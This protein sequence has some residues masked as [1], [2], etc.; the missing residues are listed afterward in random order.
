MLLGC[1]EISRV[2]GAARALE[3]Y[4]SAARR[5]ASEDG[6]AARR[7]S[8]TIETHSLGWDR[9]TEDECQEPQRK[10]RLTEPV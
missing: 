7:A 9:R 8:A 2:V 1:E 3:A 6:R 4:H 5:E 10:R